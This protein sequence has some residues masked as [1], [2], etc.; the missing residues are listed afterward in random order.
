MKNLSIHFCIKEETMATTNPYQTYKNNA[1]LTASPEELTLMLYDGAVK[2]CNQAMKSVEDKNIHEAHRLII[3]VEDIIEEFQASLNKDYEVAQS[4]DVMYEY[5]HRR[6]VEANVTKDVEI[7][8]EVCG[9]IKE[10]RDTW[11]EAMKLTK[12]KK[13]VNA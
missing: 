6:L 2:F 1:I 10:L 11:K 13:T 5:I 7:L 8:K 9:L 4:F 12:Q 3:R